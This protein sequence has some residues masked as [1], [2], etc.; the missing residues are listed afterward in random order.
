[1]FF[2][3]NIVFSDVFVK[4]NYVFSYFYSKK[5]RF[6]VLMV[7]LWYPYGTIRGRFFYKNVIFSKKSTKKVRLLVLL[8]EKT[9]FFHSYGTL[10]VPR[11]LSFTQF[12]YHKP[13]YGTL[14]VPYGTASEVEFLAYSK[15]NHT[16]SDVFTT[17]K[18]YFRRKLSVLLRF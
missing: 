3:E 11:Q 10:M 17:K 9:S 12:W 16:K 4:K 1:M 18:C 14:M 2:V 8:L 5:Q 13:P 7:P 6:F 15:E